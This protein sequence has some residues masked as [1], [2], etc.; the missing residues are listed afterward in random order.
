MLCDPEDLALVLPDQLLK[1][2]CITILR[3]RNQRYVWVDLFR[4]WGLD[5]G[6]EQKVRQFYP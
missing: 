4:S 2:S 6:H 5:G 3:A 1:G